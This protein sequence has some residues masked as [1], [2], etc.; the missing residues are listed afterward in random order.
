MFPRRPANSVRTCWS[1]STT[2]DLSRSG[3]KSNIRGL[4]AKLAIPLAALFLVYLFVRVA[5]DLPAL[6]KPRELA[7]TTAYLRIS[8]RPLLDAEFWGSARPFVFPLLLK[9][10]HQDI[11]TAAAIQLG[12]SILAW[13][14]LALS[15]S[16]SL[17]TFWLK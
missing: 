7:D 11:S 4:D 10:T 17:R 8:T 13:G 16:A 3:L 2:M 12:F 14:L 6:S 9:L 5:S 15:I 1:R